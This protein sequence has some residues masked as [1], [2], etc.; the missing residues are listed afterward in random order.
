M[1]LLGHRTHSHGPHRQLPDLFDLRHLD[2]PGTDDTDRSLIEQATAGDAAAFEELMRRHQAAVFRFI[3]A[4]GV[5]DTDAEDALQ[6]TF[7][8]AWR[9]AGTYDA[10]GGVRSWLLSIARNSVRHLRRRRVG[11]PA[12][13]ESLDALAMRAGWGEPAATI[14]IS[15]DSA[16]ARERI[17]RGLA[18]LDAEDRAVLTL[19]DL[20][21]LTGEET[22]RILQ[23][24]LPAMKSRLHRARL[25]L[26]AAIREHVD[27]RS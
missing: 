4:L 3:G 22:A 20:E 7:I 13:L 14:I 17:E 8:A 25:H 6:E 23:L 5:N 19:R 10:S 11:E 26:A 16:D 27:E 9:G 2:V 18:L 12:T 1:G 24:S 15:T 21:D